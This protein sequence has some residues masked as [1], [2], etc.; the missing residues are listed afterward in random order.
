LKKLFNYWV[1]KEGALSS[2]KR[3]DEVMVNVIEYFIINCYYDNKIITEYGMYERRLN[4]KL[5]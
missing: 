3:I 2:I 4:I 1:G 5:D